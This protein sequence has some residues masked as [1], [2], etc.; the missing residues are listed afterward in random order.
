M[1]ASALRALGDACA[2]AA[3]PQTGPLPGAYAKR[4]LPVLERRIGDGDLSL[5]HALAE[6]EAVTVELDRSLLANVN[7]P[8]ELAALS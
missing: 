3:V 7:V 2:D 6:L 1:T 4:A 5:R 8:E